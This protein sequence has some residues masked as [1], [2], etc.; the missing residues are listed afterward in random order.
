ML[1]FENTT[2][3]GGMAGGGMGKIASAFGIKMENV[4]TKKIVRGPNGR[5]VIYLPGK[6]IDELD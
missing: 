6:H 4:Y 3:I 1:K 2:Q 5:K